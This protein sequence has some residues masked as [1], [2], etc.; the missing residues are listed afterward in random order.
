MNVR[1]CHGEI[2][3]GLMMDLSGLDLEEIGNALADD[4]EAHWARMSTR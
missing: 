3:S 2:Y 1:T 4:A